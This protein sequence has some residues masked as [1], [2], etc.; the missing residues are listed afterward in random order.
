MI[1]PI[2]DQILN[3]NTVRDIQGDPIPLRGNID[4]TEGMF[5]YDLVKENKTITSTLEIG[6]AFGL[7]SLFIC[8]ALEEKE[9][10]KHII[11][12]PNQHSHYGGIGILN[13]ER[14]GV[15]FYKFIEETSEIALPKILEETPESYDL[16]FIDGLHSFDQVALDFYYANRLLKL[17]GLIIFDDCSF[18]S[19]AKVLSYAVKFPAYQFHSQVKE[20][21]NKK[22]LLR[23]FLKLL[24]DGFYTYLL[25]LKINNFYNR[26][27]FT[28]MVAIQ[29][30][31]DD[32]RS[33]D[34]FS[35]F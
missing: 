3:S 30:C 29:K 1:Y 31:S 11:I 20:E 6:C 4:R 33:N 18:A 8:S 15:R 34:W 14:A 7:S 27:R 35:D 12:D 2:I 9:N 22:K 17:G 23:F 24:P 25:P 19:I 28:S 16:V 10:P 13:L 32:Q 21:S 26:L 5:L